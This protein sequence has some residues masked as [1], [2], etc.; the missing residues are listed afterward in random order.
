MD[1]DL[2]SYTTSTS[3]NY[4]LRLVDGSSRFES[5]LNLVGLMRLVVLSGLALDVRPFRQFDQQTYCAGPDL[6]GGALAG[7]LWHTVQQTK[8]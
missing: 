6:G 8:A 4:R 7:A 3:S 2:L 5:I 1:L